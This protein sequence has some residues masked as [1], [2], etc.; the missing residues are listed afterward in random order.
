MKAD[1]SVEGFNIGANV[2]PVSGQ[3]IFQCH[4]HLI[5]H[6]KG[7]VNDALGGVRAVIPDKMR[8]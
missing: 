4:I 2:G 1:P 7:D 5:P 8:Y 3:T 6:R